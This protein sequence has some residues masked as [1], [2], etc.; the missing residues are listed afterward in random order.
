[1]LPLIGMLGMAKSLLPGVFHSWSLYGMMVSGHHSKRVKT[2]ATGLLRLSL[3]SRT[4]LLV[5]ESHINNN[6]LKRWGN[7]FH[8][9]M[10]KIAKSAFGSRWHWSY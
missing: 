7:R 2:E 9:I 8:C 10:G 4:S 1:M 5:K 3:R 6:S